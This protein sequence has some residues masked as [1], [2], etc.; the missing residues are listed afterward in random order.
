[1]LGLKSRGRSKSRKQQQQRRRQRRRQQR[2]GPARARQGHDC[3]ENVGA[4]DGLAVG[5]RLPLPLACRICPVL[6]VWRWICSLNAV[7]R[8]SASRQQTN[9]QRHH[10]YV[11]LAPSRLAEAR[12][13]GALRSV[14]E[15]TISRQISSH[16]PG[17]LS[18]QCLHR[19][20]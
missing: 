4:W 3:G 11:D 2:L 8:P 6:L 20:P 9:K 10:I 14:V 17:P 15:S 1:M 13:N 18:A 19:P 7:Q 12:H 5:C 16:R